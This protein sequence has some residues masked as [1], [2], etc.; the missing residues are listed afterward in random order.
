MESSHSWGHHPEK[1]QFC[2]IYFQYPEDPD[3]GFSVT[4][5]AFGPYELRQIKY[6][7]EIRTSGDMF[8]YVDTEKMTHHIDVLLYRRGV[9]MEKV[10]EIYEL[11]MLG[12]L[13]PF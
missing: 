11:A 1:G 10:G 13:A 5:Y 9:S 3:Y 8:Q 12:D 4:C 2:E 7:T 6:G